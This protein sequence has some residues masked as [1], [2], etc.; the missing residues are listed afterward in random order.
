MKTDWW[1]LVAVVIC[2]ASAAFMCW[3]IYRFIRM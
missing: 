2:C 3:V 1:F